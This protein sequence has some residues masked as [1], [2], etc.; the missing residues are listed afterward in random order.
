MEIQQNPAQ[1]W[2]FGVFEVDARNLELRRNGVRVKVREQSF[3]VLIHLLEH[4]GELVS[5]EELCRALWPSDTFVDFDHSLN[6]AIKKLRDALG[7]LADAPIYIE[8]VPKRGYRFV[9]PVSCVDATV[10]SQSTAPSNGHGSAAGVSGAMRSGNGL[11]GPT[12]NEATLKL[13]AAAGRP[14]P[15]SNRRWIWIGAIAALAA[16][17]VVLVVIEGHWRSRRA[18]R[19]AVEVRVTANPAEAPIRAAVVS[20]NGKYLA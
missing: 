17:A 8:T 9:A 7:D 1:K 6:T 16:T 15:L 10:P 12:A 3:R 2:R 11:H 4:A 14:T 5:R 13:T 20:P 18:A 19:P